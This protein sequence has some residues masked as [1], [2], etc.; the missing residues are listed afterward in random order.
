M[1]R[2]ERPLS[3]STGM[4]LLD[5][6]K[7]FDSVWHESL[8]HKLLSKGCNIS[9]VR[10]IFSFLKERSFQVCVG[11]AESLSCNISYSVPQGAILSPTLYII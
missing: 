6:E 4:L 11:K 3:E 7:A 8:L 2:E 9:L 1:S 5:V 10:L